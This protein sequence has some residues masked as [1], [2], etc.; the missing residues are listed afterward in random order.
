MQLSFS[1]GDTLQTTRANYQSS[2]QQRPCRDSA[3]RLSRTPEA[4]RREALSLQDV[5][6][7][8]STGSAGKSA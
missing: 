3:S 5:H 6:Q 8:A 7:L 4:D 1:N 2:E